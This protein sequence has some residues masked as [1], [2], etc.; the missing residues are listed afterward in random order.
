MLGYPLINEGVVGGQQI[1]YVVVFVEN[2]AHEQVGF[3]AQGLAEIVIEIRKLLRVGEGVLEVPQEQPLRREVGHQR[4]RAR[5]G[6]HA[7]HL[8][9]EHRRIFRACPARRR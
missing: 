9:F 4:I 5:V 6:E 1:Q 7:P 8:F 2:A 3:L